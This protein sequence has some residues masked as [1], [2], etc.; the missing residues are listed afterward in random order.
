MESLFFCCLGVS[1]ECLENNAS[2]IS[3]H[4]VSAESIAELDV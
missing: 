4:M 1:P 3:L 2:A